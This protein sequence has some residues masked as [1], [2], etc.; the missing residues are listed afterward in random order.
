MSIGMTAPNLG[1]KVK[2]AWAERQKQIAYSA[3]SPTMPWRNQIRI[4][5]V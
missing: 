3:R 1:E 4:R 2:K 5:S